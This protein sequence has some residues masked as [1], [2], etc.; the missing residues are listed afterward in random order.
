VFEIEYSR[1]NL[2][3]NVILSSAVGIDSTDPIHLV[4]V[5]KDENDATGEHGLQAIYI[6]G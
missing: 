1:K 2:N 5:L 6:N 3:C 4:F